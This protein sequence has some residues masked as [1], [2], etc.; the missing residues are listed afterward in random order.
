MRWQIASG[1][2]WSREF[3]LEKVSQMGLLWE[4]LKTVSWYIKSLQTW[5]K[6][7][8]IQPGQ[9]MTSYI[10]LH[11]KTVH[12]WNFSKA[13]CELGT[14]SFKLEFPLRLKWLNIYQLQRQFNLT[15][16]FLIEPDWVVHNIILHVQL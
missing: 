13:G 14:T 16:F 8:F 1:K 2:G 6:V 3:L 10:T 12:E 4:Y 11:L 7:D 5:I 15:Y 9:T